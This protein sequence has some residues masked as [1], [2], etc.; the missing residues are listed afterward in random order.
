[1]VIDLFKI[2]FKDHSFLYRS[3]W[4]NVDGFMKDSLDATWKNLVYDFIQAW[5]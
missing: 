3:P 2:Y 5:D 4:E 1:M